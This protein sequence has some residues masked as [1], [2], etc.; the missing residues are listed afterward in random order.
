MIPVAGIDSVLNEKY[1]LGMGRR[2]MLYRRK[3]L[4]TIVVHELN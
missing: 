3:C 2:Y 1:D 4:T